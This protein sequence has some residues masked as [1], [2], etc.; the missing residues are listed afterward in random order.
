MIESDIFT[1]EATEHHGE[2]HG[3]S[4]PEGHSGGIAPHEPES[5]HGTDEHR[6]HDEEIEEQKGRTQ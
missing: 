2:Q 5:P 3:T 6:H 4:A 1:I